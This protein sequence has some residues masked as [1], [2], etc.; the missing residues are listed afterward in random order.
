[1]DDAEKQGQFRAYL[2]PREEIWVEGCLAIALMEE[3]SVPRT[4]IANL[5]KLVDQP[6]KRANERPRGGRSALRAIF[7]ESDSWSTAQVL[8][9]SEASVKTRLSRA[10]LKM[11]D[12][13]VPSEVC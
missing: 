12:A 4:V 2:C 1:M 8:D 13:L 5:H 3:W 9:I 6:L 10:R 7:D 11:R